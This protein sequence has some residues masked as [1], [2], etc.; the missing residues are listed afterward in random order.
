[1]TADERD[2]AERNAITAIVNHVA[3]SDADDLRR[4]L[5]DAWERGETISGTSSPELS[6]LVGVLQSI[7]RAQSMARL[8]DG[9]DPSRPGDILARVCLVARLDPPHIR[10]AI[11]R[12]ENDL[13]RP[14]ILLRATDV[15][16]DDLERALRAAVFTFRR[17]GTLNR[18]FEIGRGNPPPR[19]RLDWARRLLD[20]LRDSP[21]RAADDPHS[22]Q[23]DI[24]VPLTRT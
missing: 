16:A 5:A 2:E 13:G 21:L 19:D 3:P 6:T 10:A 24:I 22:R 4:L 20:Q 9:Y 15:T 18:T 1:M 12:R 7:R 11:V 14:L 23:L 8:P 17:Y